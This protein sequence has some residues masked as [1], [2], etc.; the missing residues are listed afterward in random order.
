MHGQADLD[1]SGTGLARLMQ[2]A[3]QAGKL[4]D[5]DPDTMAALIV[6][7]G[8]KLCKVLPSVI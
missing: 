6:G 7:I 5:G 2:G 8:K 3:Q 4:R 1:P